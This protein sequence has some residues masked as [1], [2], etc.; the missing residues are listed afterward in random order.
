[1]AARVET[2]KAQ[3]TD[4]K[5]LMFHWSEA[6]FFGDCARGCLDAARFVLGMAL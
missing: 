6:D 1:M 4:N 2:N 5:W 3:E